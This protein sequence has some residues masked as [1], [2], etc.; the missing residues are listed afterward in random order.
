[1]NNTA[2]NRPF[3]RRN[4]FTLA[5]LLTVMCIIA[6]IMTASFG[7]ATK[8]REMGKKTKAEVQLRELVNAWTQY[9]QTYGKWPSGLSGAQMVETTSQMLSPLTDPD[10]SENGFGIV[11]YNY[12]G[13][14]DFKDP[15]GNPYL[16]SFGRPTSATGARAM[17]TFETTIALPRRNIQ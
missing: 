10:D 16:L 8:A 14:G 7:A 11:F 2:P 3:G 5:E 6:L 15:W 17:T 12:S 4:G 13:K 1:M 9:Y